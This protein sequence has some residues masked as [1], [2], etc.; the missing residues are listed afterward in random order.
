MTIK[1]LSG[2]RIQGL[3][4][5]TKPI[6]TQLGT[7]FDEI[8]TNKSYLAHKWATWNTSN[9]SDCV[10]DSTAGTIITEAGINGEGYA[11]STNTIKAGQSIT[12]TDF[13]NTPMYKPYGGL[14]LKASA[15]QSGTASGER[16][17]YVYYM[18][19]R[20]TSGNNALM[21]FS[22][23]NTSQADTSNN[24][25]TLD[26]NDVYKIDIATDGTVS[27]WKNGVKYYTYSQA[28]NTSTDYYIAFHGYS[29][30]G[31]TYGN[32]GVKIAW[33]QLT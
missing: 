3:S 29:D 32:T 20:H 18:E 2:R 17:N 23:N 4:S 16:G 33:E 8:D 15:T 1:Y 30:N 9:E 31:T 14:A 5:D 25:I 6:S 12:Y 28:A 21:R 10:I 22:Y 26:N 24:T 19:W 27:W 11:T 13:R 7:I